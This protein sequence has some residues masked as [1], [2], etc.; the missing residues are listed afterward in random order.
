MNETQTA[1][2]EVISSEEFDALVAT[3]PQIDRA[4]Y[5]AGCNEYFVAEYYSYDGSLSRLVHYFEP[6]F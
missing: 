2:S 5:Q 1:K 3:F 6:I 4:S